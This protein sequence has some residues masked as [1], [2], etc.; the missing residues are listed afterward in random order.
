MK[1]IITII[2]VFFPFYGLCQTP[3]NDKDSSDNY[4]ISKMRNFIQQNERLN[5]SNEVQHQNFYNEIATFVRQHPKREISFLFISWSNNLRIEQL[6]SLNNLVDTSLYNSPYKAYTDYAIRRMKAAETGKSFPELT[7]TDT[8]GNKT[9]IAD[10]K[11]KIILIDFWSSWCGP[12]RQ[13]TPELKSIYKKYNKKGFEIIGISIDESKDKWLN[14][15]TK[16]KHK[17]VNFCE[18]TNWTNNKVANRFAIGSIPSNFLIDRNGILIG[19]DL[20]I[21]KIKSELAKQY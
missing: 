19:Q 20:S 7:L 4:F 18:F 16:D 12:C 2:I 17:W 9:S 8:L 21:E 1:N 13:Q 10:L 15:I 11:G 5:V 3:F 6:Q 14:A